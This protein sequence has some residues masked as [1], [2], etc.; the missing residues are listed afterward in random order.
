MQ[1]L[2]LSTCSAL[3]SWQ[4]LIPE[5][6]GVGLLGLITKLT[7]LCCLNF[8]G[9]LGSRGDWLWQETIKLFFFEFLCQRGSK[10]IHV[11]KCPHSESKNLFCSFSTV[12]SLVGIGTEAPTFK[13]LWV[14]LTTNTTKYTQGQVFTITVQYTTP[15]RPHKICITWSFQTLNT[16]RFREQLLLLILLLQLAAKHSGQRGGSVVKTLKENSHWNSSAFDKMKQNRQE[17]SG[18]TALILMCECGRCKFASKQ[19]KC[20]VWGKFRNNSTRTK[21]LIRAKNE[22]R[23]RL[24]WVHQGISSSAF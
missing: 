22:R 12:F 8:C 15:R 9:G 5:M 13:I 23:H 10:I 21:V 20:S 19:Q 3:F 1:K 4:L 2:S 18:S 24:I 11:S 16:I 17:S 14:V 6:R 7:I